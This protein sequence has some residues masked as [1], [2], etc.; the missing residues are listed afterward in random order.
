M[1]ETTSG[2]VG[3]VVALGDEVFVVALASVD[4]SGEWVIW[5][6]VGNVSWGCSVYH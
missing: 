4:G 3:N 6:W 1:K 2:V 5:E